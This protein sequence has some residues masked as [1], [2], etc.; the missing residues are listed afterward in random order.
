VIRLIIDVVVVVVALLG[1]RG[2][3]VWVRQCI[4]LYYV[5]VPAGIA[6]LF[7]SSRDAVVMPKYVAFLRSHHSRT[8]WTVGIWAYIGVFLVGTIVTAEQNE[9]PVGLLILPL[10]LGVVVAPLLC[11]VVFA[12]R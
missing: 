10:F 7:R 6:M 5:I 12:W 8:V 1:R 2:F 3:P 9:I 11:G 4:G